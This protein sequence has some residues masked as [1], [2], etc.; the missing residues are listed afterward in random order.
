MQQVAEC[1]HEE[2]VASYCVVDKMSTDQPIV[3][4]SDGFLSL[5]G[6]NRDKIVGKVSA[7]DGRRLSPASRQCTPRSSRFGFCPAHRLFPFVSRLPRDS[8]SF[9]FSELPFPPRH[10]H[11]QGRGITPLPPPRH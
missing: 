4:V 2:T 1:W 11:L 8:L 7:P 9:L 5:T 10:R 3:E 6:Y